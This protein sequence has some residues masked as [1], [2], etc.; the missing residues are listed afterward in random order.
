MKEACGSFIT[1][2]NLAT[3]VQDA[4]IRSSQDTMATKAGGEVEPPLRKE[5]WR[6]FSS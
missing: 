1:P 2:G 5:P 4:K 3:S 6:R